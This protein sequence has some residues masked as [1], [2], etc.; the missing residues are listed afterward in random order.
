MDAI[1][2]IKERNRMCEYFG[3]ACTKDG[4]D[5]PAIN[6]NCA[7]FRGTSNDGFE[8]VNIVKKW[9][10]EHP[11]KTMLQ[12]FLE[13][14]PKAPIQHDGTPGLCPYK[15]GYTKED[16]CG[17]FILNP[18]YKTCAECWSRPVEE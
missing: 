7:T 15:C 10:Y 18:K 6:K 17:K 5:C 8:L 2:F 4:K 13:K 12:D 9:S 14:F 16:C 11:Q 3:S 1:E